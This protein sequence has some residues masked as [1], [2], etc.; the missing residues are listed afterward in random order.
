MD[1][2]IVITGT[3]AIT[4]LGHSVDETWQAVL[5]GVSGVGPIT[6]VD[7][8]PF[9]VHY[10]CEVKNFKPENF[11]EAKEARRRDR[12][13]QFAAAAA[14]EAIL[15]SGL[16]MNRED[17]YRVGVV[18]STA[19]GGLRTI[20]DGAA[21]VF[22]GDFRHVSPFVVPMLMPNGA[23]GMVSIDYGTRGPCMSV[24]SACASGRTFTSGRSLKCSAPT[25]R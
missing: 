1:E 21:L 17:P 9:A 11:M 6:L 7:S 18:V 3:G 14:R 19:L 16:D 2:R 23:A 13:E 22:K 10:A 12:Y 20:E 4:P 5:N 8:T 25:C 24:A 15:Q